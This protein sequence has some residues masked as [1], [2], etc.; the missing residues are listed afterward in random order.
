VATFSNLQPAVAAIA[1][2][3]LFNEP[4]HWALAV[5]GVLVGVRLMQTAGTRP[6]RSG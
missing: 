4:L 2:W 6:T 1:A 5:S 3:A